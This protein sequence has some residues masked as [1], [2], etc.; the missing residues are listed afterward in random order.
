MF[1]CTIPAWSDERKNEKRKKERERKKSLSK[2]KDRY[3]IVKGLAGGPDGVSF[4]SV[5][6]KKHFL[7]VRDN[8]LIV[9]AYDD[10]EEYRK[11][12]LI[13]IILITTILM[14]SPLTLMIR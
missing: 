10:S 9:E 4:E 13:I 1:S 3:T 11:Y 2:G 12:I 7:R 5:S 6:K 8:V 14:N